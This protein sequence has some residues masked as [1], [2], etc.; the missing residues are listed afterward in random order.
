MSFPSFRTR[1]YARVLDAMSTAVVWADHAGKIRLMNPAAEALFGA[2]SRKFED[3]PLV[4][5]FID[6]NGLA[7]HMRTVLD[8]GRGISEWQSVFVYRNGETAT[9]DYTLTPLTGQDGTEVLFE[10]RPVDRQLEISRHESLRNQQSISRE[11]VRGF[12]HEIKNP[13]GGLRGSAQLLE[14]E[15][16]DPELHEYTQVIIREADRLRGLVDRMLGPNH[17][18]KFAP[19]N[20]HLVAER[21]RQLMEAE[22]GGH[23]E[24]ERD[25]DPSIPEVSGDADQLI[26]ALLNIARNAQ[27][28]LLESHTADPQLVIRTRTMRRIMIGDSLVPN[29]L[30]L[31]VIDNGPG[32]PAERMG[33]IFYPLITGRAEGTGLGLP[34]AQTIIMQHGGEIEC[35]S[36]PGETC[37]TIY[38]PFDD[39]GGTPT[40][41]NEKIHE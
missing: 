39:G 38:L 17:L 30:K 33:Q 32:I 31:E 7:G 14:A 40:K 19:L 25:Y 9:L 27:Q 10:A 29:A 24:V 21:V 26:Q 34:M 37:F 28:S 36:E 41:T 1:P 13:L 4:D 35:R 23:I 8:T 16:Q 2:S 20:I 5:V 6:S 3:K 15:L 22:T 12:A 11:V 18:P